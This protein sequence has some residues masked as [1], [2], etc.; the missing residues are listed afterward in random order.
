MSLEQAYL[1]REGHNEITKLINFFKSLIVKNNTEAKEFETS[2]VLHNYYLYTTA[3][4]DSKNPYDY[5][6][7]YSE[8]SKYFSEKTISILNLMTPEGLSNAMNNKIYTTE[9][10]AFMNYLQNKTIKNY[11]EQNQYYRQFMG[12][13]PTNDDI[14]FVENLDN[15]KNNLDLKMVRIDQLSLETYPNTYEHYF[16]KNK[17]NDLIE[18]YPDLLYLRFINNKYSPYY[19]RTCPDFTILYCDK[20]ILSTDEYNRFE[21][22]YKRAQNYVNEI[23]YVVGMEDRFPLYANIMYLFILFYT[24]QIYNNLK[25]KDYS[26]TKYT[27]FDLYDILDSNNLSSLKKLSDKSLIR[28]VVMHMDILKEYKGSE[29][30]LS[31]LFDL[32]ADNSVTV[33][34]YDLIKEFP[35]DLTNSLRFDNTKTYD[36]QV[37]LKFKEKIIRTAES[38]YSPR[39]VDYNT[40]VETDE[41]WGGT[42]DI[43]DDSS[44]NKIKKELKNKILS[45]DFSSISTKY[46][47]ISKSLN[48]YE[49]SIQTSNILY[50]I[51]RYCNNEGLEQLGYNPLKEDKIK[52]DDSGN[53]VEPMTLFAAI[54]YFQSIIC[55]LENPS[56]ISNDRCILANANIMRSK[57]GIQSLIKEIENTEIDISTEVLKKP[58]KEIITNV[59]INDFLIKYDIEIASSLVNIVNEYGNNEKI[60]NKLSELILSSDNAE[61]YEAYH[62]LYEKN[63]VDYSFAGAFEGYTDYEDYI[64]SKNPWFFN[65]KVDVLLSSIEDWDDRKV[66]IETIGM[67]INEW[68]KYFQ[69]YLTDLIKN[70]YSINLLEGERDLDYLEDLKLLL[71]EFLSIYSELYNMEHV[72]DV[73]DQPY[74]TL[75]LYYLQIYDI[76]KEDLSNY[77]G[78][79]II[80]NRDILHQIYSENM[81]LAE[82]ISEELL[83]SYSEELKILIETNYDKL[84]EEY[85][86]RAEIVVK[87]LEDILIE[88]YKEKIEMFHL[89]EEVGELISMILEDKFEIYEEI[90]DIFITSN[91]DVMEIKPI[92]DKNILY[93][94]YND[95]FNLKDRIKIKQRG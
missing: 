51:M 9:A 81:S 39:T 17:V 27:D 72:T 10:N 59:S 82:K 34:R 52:I 62:Y 49:N 47:S 19:L 77:I 58:I 64:S 73:S 46:I 78:L 6:W 79:K 55:G 63:K 36:N 16:I 69:N 8:I 80:N 68:L 32:I 42:K 84:A 26:L 61:V 48:I 75:K 25:L 70:I 89:I 28:K 93:E 7:S 3:Y 21:Q 71:T 90:D 35:V 85:V 67:K 56:K 24:F 53:Y 18:K 30:I 12:L 31:L 87:K 4:T 57:G 45:M 66:L 94:S 65:N 88:S 38:Y 74:N 22:A 54:C 43:E 91:E 40:L 23:L 50:L 76:L 11:G 60:M 13:P 33:K 5:D 92:L 2:E 14:I 1:S 37:D 95:Y 44:K 29:Y 41:M 86:N 15:D 20:T 83:I